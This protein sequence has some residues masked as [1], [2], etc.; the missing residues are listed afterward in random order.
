MGPW[1]DFW[2]VPL[3]DAMVGDV[4]PALRML[5]GAVTFVLLIG[6]ANV[7]TLL[8]SRGAARDREMTVRLAVGAD[9]ARLVRQ[10]LTE[11]VVLALVGATL[12][13][14]LAFAGRNV[15]FALRSKL[16][17]SL[18]VDPAVRPNS[19]ERNLAALQ[20]IDQELP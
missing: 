2:A 14:A 1:E 7:A 6:C 5:S 8:L 10:L 3:R 15:L 9:R 13:L 19:I 17:Q 4:K 11:S 20:Q 16:D 18:E 12:G